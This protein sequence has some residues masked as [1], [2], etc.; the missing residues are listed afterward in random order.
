MLKF[1]P[2][3]RNNFTKAPQA[4]NNLGQMAVL[5]KTSLMKHR[6]TMCEIPS[7]LSHLCPVVPG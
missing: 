4:P 5:L 6:A 2:S 7:P 1:A 3:V